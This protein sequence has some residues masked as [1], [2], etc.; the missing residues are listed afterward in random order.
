MTMSDSANNLLHYYK[1]S[2]QDRY[3]LQIKT[4]VQSKLFH[5]SYYTW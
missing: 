1:K 2:I 4:N 3:I 5:F